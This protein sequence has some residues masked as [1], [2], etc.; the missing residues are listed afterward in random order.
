MSKAKTKKVTPQRIKVND[1]KELDESDEEV[2]KVEKSRGEANPTIYIPPP[3][4]QRLHKKEDRDKLRKFMAK[5][6]NLSINISLLEV[7]QKILG[8]AKLMKKLMS[9]KKLI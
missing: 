6:R 4:P 9:K 8:Y 5:L 3:F 2:V 1:E 7:I